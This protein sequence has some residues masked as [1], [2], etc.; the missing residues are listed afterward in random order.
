MLCSLTL[1]CT[2]NNCCHLA[3]LSA[4]QTAKL[5]IYLFFIKKI[6]IWAKYSVNA[7]ICTVNHWVN[8]T[9]SIAVD[10]L[11]LFIIRS[12]VSAVLIFWEK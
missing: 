2:Y 8:P 12:S 6:T 7:S 3:T 9:G 5:F 4:C 1:H 10:A 11:H